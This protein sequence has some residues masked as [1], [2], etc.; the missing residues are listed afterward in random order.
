M[1]LNLVKFFFST[2]IFPTFISNSMVAESLD[3]AGTFP[4]ATLASGARKDWRMV[5]R[6]QSFRAVEAWVWSTW[7]MC[8]CVCMCVC[9]PW[10][11][12][13]ECAGGSAGWGRDAGQ[14]C[15]AQLG[16]G[17]NTTPHSDWPNSPNNI[18]VMNSNTHS[19][20]T[21]NV[22][23]TLGNVPSIQSPKHML[24]SRLRNKHHFKF[25]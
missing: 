8:S 11:G 18:Q 6:H 16:K 14:E 13:C 5:Y 23:V 21:N 25:I 1:C 17:S 15:D 12:A 20:P 2:Y 4:A 3:S 10:G 7:V 9:Y 19:L 24:G 22:S